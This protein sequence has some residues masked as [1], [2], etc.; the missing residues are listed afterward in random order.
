MFSNIVKVLYNNNVRIREGDKWKAVFCMNHGLFEP[1]MMY[2]RLTNSPATFQMMMNDIFYNLILEGVVCI[3]LDN[4]LI[5]TNSREEHDHI[6]HLVLEC[7]CKHKLYLHFDKCE[8][9]KTCIEYLSIILSQN[10]VEM[11]LV[12]IAG[13][14]EWPTPKSKKEVQSFVGFINFYHRFIADFSLHARPLFD[15]TK[16]DVLF[17]WGTCEDFTFNELKRM[18]TSAPVLVMLDSEQPYRVEA[19]G[20]GVATG[21]VL[22][23]LSCNNEK[24]HPVAYQSKSL[25]MVER[26]YEI[27]NTE[28]LVIV[29]ALEEWHHYL[30]GA[31]H[32][33]EVWTNHKNLEY[34]RTTQKLNRHQARWSLYLSCFDFSLHHKP[35]H[36]MGKPD[37]LSRHMDQGSG[38]DDNCDMTLLSLELFQIQALVGLDLIGAEQK[39]MQDIRHSL[40]VSELEE[41]ITKAVQELRKDHGRM[42]VHSAEWSET[43]SL[44]TYCGKIYI[45]KNHNLHHRIIAQHHDSFIAGHPGRW[46]TLEL[47]LCNYWWP[48]MSWFIGLYVCTCDPCN[49]TKLPHCLLQGE[50]HPMETPVECWD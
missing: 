32:L 24:W 43:D 29:Q 6:S 21:T 11:D 9:A 50:L 41:S 38:H 28:M 45:P 37:A 39:I 1:L 49:C 35:G 2:F 36:S 42:S 17:I 34:F 40:G 7:L 46:K 20:S 23:Q 48:Q 16:K 47:T 27:H 3:Y 14:A 15:L 26:N 22:S 12:K 4:I 18:V 33:I 25:S 30:E 5:F 19:D 10:H 31:H 13:V 44:L 8:F